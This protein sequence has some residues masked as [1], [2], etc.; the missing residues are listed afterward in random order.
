MTMAI[1][2][3]RQKILQKIRQSLSKT[4]NQSENHKVEY[5]S[6]KRVIDYSQS[7]INDLTPKSTED[8]YQQ[9]CA[10]V[11]SQSSDLIE[12]NSVDE[13][14]HHLN[15][16]L[17]SISLPKD[18]WIVQGWQEFNYLNWLDYSINYDTNNHSINHHLGMSG[19]D[20]AIAETGTVAIQNSAEKKL[21][22]SLLPETHLLIVRKSQIVQ[23]LFVAAS[24]VNLQADF[25][26][27]VFISGPSRTADIEQTIVLGAHGPRRVCIFLI[28]D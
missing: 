22:P 17:Q 18:K 25:E 10:Q 15:I 23:N 28:N 5:S 3:S 2:D 1:M 9:F 16:Y 4:I 14:P 8:L 12:L 20:F 26:Q 6:K 7:L 27:L 13:V 19:C 21:K 11:K 24:Q